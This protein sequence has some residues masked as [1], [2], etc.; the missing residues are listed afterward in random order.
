MENTAKKFGKTLSFIPLACFAAWTI[1][2]FIVVQEAVV[3]SSVFDHFLWVMAMIDH[4]TSLAITLGAT[5]TVAAAILIYFTVHIA[6]IKKMPAGEK[7]A[8]MVFLV[9][10]GAFSFPVFWYYELRNEPDRIDVHP[11]IA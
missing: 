1:Y 3:T 8:W 10:F 7:V 9:I 11:S 5:C 2:F 6:R 4:Y